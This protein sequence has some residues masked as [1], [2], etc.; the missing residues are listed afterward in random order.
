MGLLP[1]LV[2]LSTFSAVAGP[3]Y[4]GS[5]I[6]AKCHRD[7]ASTQL[8]SNM[9]I[10]WQGHAPTL[11]PQEYQR[12]K[13]EGPVEYNLSRTAKGITYK[14]TLPGQPSA[15]TPVETVVGGRRHGLSFLIRVSELG[16]LKLP[17]SPLIESRYLHYVHSGQLVLS[18]GFPAETPSSW[19]TALG[20][21]L[22]PEF[23]QKCLTCHGAAQTG[24]HETGVRCETCHGPGS[25]H[26]KAV[27]ASAARPTDTAILNPRNLSNDKL[28]LQCSQCHSGFSDLADPVPDDLL[29][30]N[31]VTALQKSQCYIQSGAGLSCLS[32]HDPHHDAARSDVKPL[33]ACLSCHSAAAGKRAAL[34]PVNQKGQCMA[35]HMPET[36]KGSFH[37]VDHWIR[38]HP[39]QG[40]KSAGRDPANRTTIA[41]KRLYLRWIVAENQPKAE[42]ALA[43]L[44][45]GA[46][47]FS[48]AQTYSTDE[49]SISGGYLGDMSV[50]SLDPALAAAALKIDRGEFSP[51]VD[52]KGK[53]TI[54]YRMPRDFLYEA[55]Q[56]N[57]EG[58]RLRESGKFAEAANKYLESLQI[59]PYFLRSLIFLAVSLGQ[60]GQPQRAAPILEFASQLYP[61]DPAAQYNLA[62]TLGTIGH[63][64]EEIVAYRR[65]IDMQPDLIPAYL[66]LGATLHAAGRLDEA[67]EAYRRGLIQNPLA[68][69]LYHNLAQVYQQM[70]RADQA[71][72]ADAL[73]V[74]I[75]PKLAKAR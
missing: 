67:V 14:V 36:Q 63:T 19:D 16:G 41:P 13:M 9:G 54:V 34:C 74:K 38:V 50:S 40:V 61:K 2:L 22:S 64:D 15:Q 39:E 72:R 51:I 60:Q 7:I 18:P 75:D 45:R 53:P 11:L 65:A 25:D 20:R 12:T 69:G 24:M 27:T 58:T 44:K 56:L 5:A 68:A 48:V 31:Q 4:V 23:E 33:R 10:T 43:E 52:V 42:E 8:N 37:M 49:H 71:A 66:N 3:A 28:L 1:V 46:P 26:V 32:C 29:I 62:I 59:Y 47:F 70:G 35:C 55:E 17:A 30:S 57:L 6:C 73:A 21:V